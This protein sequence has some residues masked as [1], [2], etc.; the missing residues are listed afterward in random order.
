MGGHDSEIM[1][2]SLIDRGDAGTPDVVIEG[3]ANA[4]VTTVH[5]GPGGGFGGAVSG[6]S[7]WQ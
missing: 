2:D 7:A 3:R 4:D 6:W 1:D 5:A